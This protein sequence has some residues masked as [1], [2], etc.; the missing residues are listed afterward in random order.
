MQNKK[1][2]TSL[3]VKMRI[4]SFVFCLPIIAISV[5]MRITIRGP[6]QD[7]FIKQHNQTVIQEVDYLSKQIEQV[8][9]FTSSWANSLKQSLVLFP[10]EDITS[11]QEI[12]NI[13]K[14]ILFFENSSSLIKDSTIYVF[15]PKSPFAIGS[16]GTWSLNG[17]DQYPEY[18][19]ETGKNF[20]WRLTDRGELMFIQQL[21]ERDALTK[22]T[23]STVFDKSEIIELIKVS[24]NGNEMG[25]V[26][27]TVDNQMVVH[28]GDR[29]LSELLIH[30]PHATS[31][32]QEELEGIPYSITSKKMN[33]LTQDWY[34]YSAIPLNM[35]VQP[36]VSLSNILLWGGI[37]LFLI[38]VCLSQW[39]TKRQYQPIN[40]F[41]TSLFGKEKWTDQN[42]FEFLMSKWQQ[43]I[44]RQK[45][46]ELQSNYANVKMKY[47]I[48]SQ[49][50][51]GTYG[52]L[53]E[54]EM[55]SLMVRHGWTKKIT[56]FQLL[57]IR[58]T[59]YM[60]EA[61]VAMP[62]NLDLFILE[63]IIQETAGK[64]FYDFSVAQHRKTGMVLFVANLTE[65]QKRSFDEEVQKFGNKVTRRH[66]TII[67]SRKETS[68]NQLPALLKE[69]EQLS[70]HQRL[71]L[72]NQI[73]TP[74]NKACFVFQ[75]IFPD[76]IEKKL[77]AQVE[78]R[79]TLDLKATLQEFI[80]ALVAETRIQ[81]YVMDGTAHLYDQIRF[82][83]ITNHI[84]EVSFITKGA[85]FDK[86][87]IILQP[88]QM[89]ELLF[90]DF[91]M[92]AVALLSENDKQNT[93]MSIQNAVRFIQEHYKDPALSLEETAQYAGMDSSYF[94]KEFKRIMDQNF[95][96]FLTDL[97]IEE[98][99]VLLL[100]TDK[101]IN[102]IAEEIGYNSS[103]FNRLFK[104]KVGMT[105]GQFRNTWEEQESAHE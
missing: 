49:I 83:L 55:N 23:M 53:N 20:L 8:E 67:E 98:S 21:S 87:K 38:L 59:D 33:R 6:I 94:S 89:V 84:S 39:Y 74:A 90:T 2:S 27:L 71:E 62:T 93:M 82:L 40:E 24:A 30:S 65:E 32:W 3:K 28:S 25:N 101:R 1:K 9:L 68:L 41:M 34:F 14:D 72:T 48:V 26:T 19:I 54:D 92:P 61:S 36:L 70:W 100:Y 105:P 96:D 45:M 102:E 51:D 11:F 79:N 104:K 75:Q 37:L 58:L 42:E 85:L 17:A 44:E 12:K 47:S 57:F 86:L 7:E 91:L 46:L 95:I 66:I 22:I 63:N 97:R 18:Q 52:Y 76:H 64:Y 29:Q 35:I 16:S 88:E 81:G 99:K 69:V 103:Y 60:E 77:L 10:I 43:L 78:R 73:I 13:S 50:M 80:E 4:F 31:V 56:D 15:D 5:V